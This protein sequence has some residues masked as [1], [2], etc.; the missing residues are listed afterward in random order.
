MEK[1]FTSEALSAFIKALDEDPTFQPSKLILF[2]YNFQSKFL[3]ETA[4][5]L[6]SYKN[7]KSIE[8]DVVVRY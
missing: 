2:G 1:N 8:L 3:R 6:K 5:G 4:E 7:K